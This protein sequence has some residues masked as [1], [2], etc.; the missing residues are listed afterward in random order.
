MIDNSYVMSDY[1]F[2]IYDQQDYKDTVK[3]TT[4]VLRNLR[5]SVGGFDAIAF[6]GSSGAA[7]AYPTSLRLC[8]ALLHVR[9][10]DGSHSKYPVEGVMGLKSYVILD[11]FI[12]SGATVKAIVKAI[13]KSHQS[14]CDQVPVLKAIVLYAGNGTTREWRKTT[15]RFHDLIACLGKEN[16]DCR[17]V[18]T[19]K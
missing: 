17:V 13:R 9:K 3:R 16:C 4:K 1:L 10:K 7:L 8:T 18:M 11:D 19:Q 5:K 14:Y 2:C 12:D 15:R 6:R